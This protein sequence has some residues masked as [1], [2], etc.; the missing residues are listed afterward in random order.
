MGV[1]R[2]LM[3]QGAACPP[4]LAGMTLEAVIV[5]PAG[6]MALRPG[7]LMAGCAGILLMT[8]QAF[9]PVPGS[10][11]AMGLQPPQIVVGGGLCHLVTLPAG[12]LAVTHRTSLLILA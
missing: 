1:N 2:P 7:L 11:D 12:R 5:P 3:A 9:R 8:H 6:V 10:L 4:F